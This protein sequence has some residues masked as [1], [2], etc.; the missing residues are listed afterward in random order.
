MDAEAADL[1]A[2]ALRRSRS[3]EP[4]VPPQRDPDRPSGFQGDHKV[5]AGAPHRLDQ[6]GLLKI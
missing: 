6:V 3:E 4:R 2:L 1:E 5:M